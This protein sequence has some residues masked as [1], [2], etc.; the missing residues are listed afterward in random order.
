M[1]KASELLVK[2]FLDPLEKVLDHLVKVFSEHGT[3]IK[4]MFIKYLKN[5]YICWGVLIVKAL[6]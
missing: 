2:F 6:C 3:V 1:A 5:P 4:F